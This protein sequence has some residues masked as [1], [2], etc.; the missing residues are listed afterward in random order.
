[1]AVRAH[2]G[3]APSADRVR[4]EGRERGAGEPLRGDGLLLRVE[5]LAVLVLRVD[6][7]RARGA[8]RRH[9]VAVR[10][11]VVAQHE[12]VVA[13][14]L[15]VVLGVVARVG[16]LEVE[17]GL[18]A[19][20]R[21]RQVAAEARRDPGGVA[22][23]A[24][25]LVAGVRELAEV[26]ER[27]P[28]Q[29]VG[30]HRLRQPGA[31]VVVLV[32]GRDGVD[33]LDDLPLHARVQSRLLEDLAAPLLEPG[34]ERRRELRQ[35]G[36]VGERERGRLV[37]AAVAV[38]APNLRRGAGLAVE[39]AVAVVVAAE[40]AVDAVH[41]LLEVDVLEVHGLVEL[42]RVREVDRPAL[43]V[44]EIALLVVP[45][46]VAEDPAVAV[47]V[48]DLGVRQLRVERGDLLEEARVAPEAARGRTLRVVAFD[49][50][51][52]PRGA[53]EALRRVEQLAVGLVVPPHRAVVGVDDV[54]AGVH[55]ADDALRR[56]D[57][58]GQNMLDRVAPLLP[59]DR[60]IGGRRRSEVAEFRVLAGVRRVAVVG[61]DHVTR[62]A[63]GGAKVAGVVVGAE[64][65]QRRVQ[66]ARLLQSQE[67]RVGAQ[68]RAE[69]ADR[70]LVVRAALLDGGGRRVP[71]LRHRLAA[72]L[73]HAQDVAR[74]RDLPARQRTERREDALR[75][76]L[77]VG[78]RGI[79]A[80]HRRK[81]VARVELAERH[82]LE[83]VRAVVVQRRAPQHRPVPHH[84]RRDVADLL[85]V[86]L[87]GPAGLAGDPQVARV[88][89]AHEL[90]ALALPARGGD[91]GVA[92]ALPEVVV[93]RRDMGLSLRLLVG[94]RAGRRSRRHRHRGVAAVAGDAGHLHR[95]ALVRARGVGGGVAAHAAGD[96]G[97]GRRRGRRL[98]RRWGGGRDRRGRLLRRGSCQ[99]DSGQRDA[100][101]RAGE[102]ERDG[103]AAHQYATTSE[104]NP[105]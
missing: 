15:E 54:G 44:E 101:E 14:R 45:V 25:D 37:V 21:H 76:R 57:R 53:V 1:M 17:V 40:V 18:L 95:D 99:Q 33:R 47:E 56:G 2:L 88:H 58:V 67:D 26:T 83:R 93:A 70:E 103:G 59:R 97:R 42:L 38:D 94:R 71:D 66:Q 61:V 64:H 22:R 102:R 8:D 6:Q 78:R 24:G 5:P 48:V 13:Q 73:E 36:P 60:R 65:V 28:G 68:E 62:R 100:H 63:P 46:H 90:R 104:A 23:L 7:H 34:P 77:V 80:G 86:A 41:P 50:V 98:R 74:L 39:V 84:G 52:L 55:V 85:R 69:P 96:R 27:A 91:L 4:V 75:P 82:V 105:W 20:R 29:A 11:R 9:V 30:L 12:D 3:L 16:A 51:D 32:A 72:P 79:R 87:L 19:V 10:G 49:R 89:E 31:L 81:P 35:V 92:R 43:R